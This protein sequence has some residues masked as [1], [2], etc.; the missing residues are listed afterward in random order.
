MWQPPSP[1]Q[2]DADP[3]GQDEEE[4][5]E[6]EQKTAYQRLLSTLSTPTGH[7]LSEESSDSEEEEEEEELLEDGRL[8]CLRHN[9]TLCH[10]L[11]TLFTL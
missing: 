2:S 7:D 3:H 4:E 5:E 9:E 1:Q 8:F 6:P 10:Q 11:I